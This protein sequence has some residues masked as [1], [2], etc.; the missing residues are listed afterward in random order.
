MKGEDLKNLTKY[1]QLA[2]IK[3][4]TNIVKNVEDLANLVNY[5]DLMAD[6]NDLLII[7]TVEE[8]KEFG[9]E[10]ESSHTNRNLQGT[11]IRY[12]PKP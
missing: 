1:K 12:V 11:S 7:E 6:V 9:P 8:F 10:R 3:F 2:T 4:A 5:M